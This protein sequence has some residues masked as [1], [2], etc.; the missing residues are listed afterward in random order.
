MKIKVLQENGA[1]EVMHA[2]LRTGIA[3]H[4]SVSRFGHIFDIDESEHSQ[5]EILAKVATKYGFRKVAPG[6]LEE[7][8]YFIF[9]ADKTEKIGDNVVWLTDFGG[10]FTDDLRNARAYTQA[11]IDKDKEKYDSET[12]VPIPVG[13][14]LRYHKKTIVNGGGAVTCMMRASGHLKSIWS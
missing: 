8:R 4:Y 3:F 7:Q 9:C 5:A 6:E 13:I 11:E 1:E 10:E 2:L 12:R 14:A